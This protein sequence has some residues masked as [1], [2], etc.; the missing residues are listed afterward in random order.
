MRFVF[1]A[2]SSL[3]GDW[4]FSELSSANAIIGGG[5]KGSFLAVFLIII[6]QIL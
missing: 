2:L 1:V 6:F 5:W 4:S 3:I